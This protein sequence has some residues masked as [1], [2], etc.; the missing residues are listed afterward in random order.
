MTD[1]EPEFLDDEISLANSGTGTLV[2]DDIDISDETPEETALR[3]SAEE[4]WR[5]YT[6]LRPRKASP[7]P[8]APPL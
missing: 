6:L 4:S 5:Q 3:T 2:F 1:P 8:W 7:F